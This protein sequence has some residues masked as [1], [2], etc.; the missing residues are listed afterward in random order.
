LIIKTRE[1]QEVDK[2][3]SKFF[4]W[5]DI[6]FNI[7]KKNPFYNSTFE[8]ATIVGLGCKGPSYNDLRGPLL[9]GKRL[10]ALR[11]SLSS[12][13]SLDASLCQTVGQMGRAG[14]F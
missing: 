1:K 13:N 9:Q 8:A 4:P 12:G 3:V 2:L 6:P 7:A 10:V 11:D 5:S 14:P